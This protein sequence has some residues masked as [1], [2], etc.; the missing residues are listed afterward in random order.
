MELLPE[1]QLSAPF[2]KLAKK[3]DVKVKL[4]YDGERVFQIDEIE[5][6]TPGQGSAYLKAICLLAD[7]QQVELNVYVRPF[8]KKS[9][10]EKELMTWYKSFGFKFRGRQEDVDN[11]PWLQREPKK[12]KVAASI[13]REDLKQELLQVLA[14]LNVP[15]VGDKVRLKDL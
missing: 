11:Q 1:D 8:G 7:E 3:F 14:E 10:T 13:S 15:V 9:K 5:S 4:T 2:N 12:L 6:K